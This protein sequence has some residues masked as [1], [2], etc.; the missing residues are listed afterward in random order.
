MSLSFIN[1]RKVTW[2]MLKTSGFA[3]G[4]QHFHRDLANVKEWKIMFD[5]SIGTC[6]FFFS[7][8]FGELSKFI[9]LLSSNT[10]LLSVLL[11]KKY[12][13]RHVKTGFLHMRKQRRADQLRYIRLIMS[14]SAVFANSG[15]VVFGTSR[16]NLSRVMRKQTFWFPTWCDTNQAVQLQKMARGLK[17]RI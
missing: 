2:K 17:F 5:P 10:H 7:F 8:F 13:P 4:F 15:I 14:E 9:L 6:N 12:E 3:L 16:T 11:C 1:I